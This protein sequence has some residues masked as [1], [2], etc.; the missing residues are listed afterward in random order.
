MESK[1]KQSAMDSVGELPNLLLRECGY[2]HLPAI[3]LTPAPKQNK[4]KG[5]YK[6]DTKHS[7]AI[8]RCKEDRGGEFSNALV[9]KRTDDYRNLG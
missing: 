4:F 9:G 7:Q 1:L 6:P 3:P 8:E 2:P 5:T